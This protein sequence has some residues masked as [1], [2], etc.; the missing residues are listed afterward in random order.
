MAMY[1]EWH[2]P[3]W[4][5]GKESH[6]GVVGRAWVSQRMGPG[7][8]SPPGTIIIYIQQKIKKSYTYMINNNR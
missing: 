3:Y 4:G 5:R 8:Q 1:R 6:I 2:F 7:F